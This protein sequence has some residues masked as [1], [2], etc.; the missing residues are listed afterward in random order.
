MLA[1]IHPS[2]TKGTRRGAGSLDGPAALGS[3]RHQLPT[4][5][6]PCRRLL[7]HP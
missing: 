3:P 2:N 5:A 6:A 4:N 7:S 1:A